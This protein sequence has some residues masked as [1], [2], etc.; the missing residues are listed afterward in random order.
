M[1]G[2]WHSSLGP[3]RGRRRTHLEHLSAV[4]SVVV[5]GRVPLTTL[6]SQTSRDYKRL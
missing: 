3:S 6:R 1:E 2:A 4:C 5:A